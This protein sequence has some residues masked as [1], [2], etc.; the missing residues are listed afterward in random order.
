MLQLEN[1]VKEFYI[2]KENTVIWHNSNVEQIFN[3]W[4]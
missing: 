4:E 1:E 3:I 2:Q